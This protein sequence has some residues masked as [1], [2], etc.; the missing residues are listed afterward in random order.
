MKKNN[1]KS[2]SECSILIVDDEEKV[3]SMLK[4]ALKSKYQVE[5]CYS[6]SDAFDKIEL[7]SYDIVV[8]DLKLN[9]GHGIDILKRAKEKDKYIEVIIITGYGSFESAADA[10]NLGV[11][12]YLNKPLKIDEFT[13][14]VERAIGSRIF[15][16]RSVSLIN[17][18]DYNT[19]PDVQKHILDI[20]SLN[21]ITSKLM[22][23]LDV[24]EAI[25][26]ILE[27]INEKLNSLY[28]VI[29][30]NYLNF[31]ELFI[32]PKY[33][34]LRE[35]E[36]IQSILDNWQYSFNIFRKNDLRKEKVYIK[37][38][39]GKKHDK[40]IDISTVK[41]CICLPMSI[42]GETIGFIALFYPEKNPINEDRYQFFY[43]YT[44]L[45]T[46][47]IQHCYLDLLAKQQA[48]TD[49]L[50]G[51][52]NHRMFHEILERELARLHRINR[53]FCL[54]MI[55]ID[56]FKK[57]NDNYGHLVG[58]A[59]LI[60]LTKRISNTIRSGDILARYGGEEFALILYDTD[61]S[62]ADILANRL[63]QVISRTPLS[64]S[65]YEISYTVSIG[66][67]YCNSSIALEKDIIIGRADRALYKAK[68]NGKNRV[69]SVEH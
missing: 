49:G 38:F 64:Y 18:S 54:A 48:K 15:H 19:I 13:M 69:E 63:C 32:T 16:M 42:L 24:P 51:V 52:A 62:G 7:F 26:I 34:T 57:V 27:D 40:C 66:L 29:G 36:I 30:I 21:Y 56:D 14:Q 1:F 46:S 4:E 65:E 17:E 59:V 53:Q 50:T 67:V 28:A 41:E 60:D 35:G 12:S 61:L 10:I 11:T 58:D 6:A 20:T 43:V 22:F 39:S 47:A 31:H 55:D 37:I 33:G 8:T 5:T 3:C 2:P 68:S 23:P 25:Q 9:D 44:S 45:I